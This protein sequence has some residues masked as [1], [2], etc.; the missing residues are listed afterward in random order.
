MV[1][2]K[3]KSSAIYRL[4]GSVAQLFA[5]I[6]TLQVMDRYPNLSDLRHKGLSGWYFDGWVHLENFPL[7]R[8]RKW[9]PYLYD[10]GDIIA[11]DRPAVE[12]ILGIQPHLKNL[13]THP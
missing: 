11:K 2:L 7:W 6:L 12:Q 13:L 1:V 5:Q 10:S 3:A 9:I 8:S 4:I